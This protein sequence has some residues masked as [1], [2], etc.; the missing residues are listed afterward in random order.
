V[1]TL[2]EAAAIADRL[3]TRDPIAFRLLCLACLTHGMT[4]LERIQER[5]AELRGAYAE[6]EVAS[7]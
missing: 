1:I 6:M 3:W 5:T 7:V 4:L 2:S